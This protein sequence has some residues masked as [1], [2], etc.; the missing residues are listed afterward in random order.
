MDIADLILRLFMHIAAIV[1][2]PLTITGGSF[3]RK[4][5]DGDN[6]RLFGVRILNGELHLVIG[7]INQ[8]FLRAALSS[9]ALPLDGQN[10]IA[11]GNVQTWAGERRGGFAVRGVAKDD[12]R[13]GIARI[14]G[15][16]VPIDA[17]KALT[18][19]GA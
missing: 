16:V 5:L 7:L 4:R 15:I 12:A 11:L 14:F 2:N 10:S 13:N 9:N 19:V 6:A 3:V 8:Q 17:Q 18:I 1:F